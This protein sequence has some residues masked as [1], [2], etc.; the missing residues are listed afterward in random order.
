ML[1]VKI[2][3]TLSTPTK[4]AI[5]GGGSAIYDLIRFASNWVPLISLNL[6]YNLP[7]LILDQGLLDRDEGNWTI[8]CMDDSSD[9]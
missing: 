6:S 4:P 9:L 2:T 8:L 5:I 1:K 7:H 3:G